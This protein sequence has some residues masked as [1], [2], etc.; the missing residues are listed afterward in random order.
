MA[1][2]YNHKVETILVT[3]LAKG[4]TVAQAARQA[5]VGE[6][7]VYR[8]R[9][10]PEFQARITAV[11]NETLERV[12][13]ILTTAAEQGI[14][15]LV[16]LQSSSTPAHVRRAAARDILE[17]GVRLRE[18]ADLEK[19]LEALESGVPR[20][21]GGI[22]ASK[23]TSGSGTGPRRR[24]GDIALQV[25][26]ASGDSVVQAAAKAHI[27]ERTAYRRLDEPGFR[28]AIDALRAEMVERA[29]ALLIAA[30]LLATKTLIDLQTSTIPAAVRRGASRDMLE[31]ARKLREAVFL[32]KRI[33]ALEKQGSDLG[34]QP[35]QKSFF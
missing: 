35:R 21:N 5:G 7:T 26:L 6:R 19:R 11:Q 17:I 34:P 2:R 32:E 25:A 22:M 4:S 29:A 23:P 1:R 10:Q 24:R 33:A 20:N 12:V 9:Q 30:A 27:S 14:H 3:A 31:M 15:S 18:A 28:R 16:S 8:R 13:S